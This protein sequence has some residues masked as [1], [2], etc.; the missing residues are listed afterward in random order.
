MADLSTPANITKKTAMRSEI[1]RR[2]IQRQETGVLL[3]LV[4]MCVVIT[5]VAP[6]F[7][8]KQNMY[9]LSRQISLLAIVALGEF[10]TILTGGIDLSVGSIIGFSGVMCGLSLASGLPPGIA[11]ILG[12][13]AGFGAGLLTGWLV[14]YVGLTPF[15]PTLGML[16]MARGVIW[17]ITKGWPVTEIPEAF[18]VLGR[19]EV[20]GIPFPVVI[21][22]VLALVC[23]GVLKYT[24]FG[25]RIFAIGGN[26]E[27]AS[28]SGV[29]V[30]RIKLFI[31]AISSFCASITGIIM[32]ARFNSAQASMGVSWELD[33]IASAVI[34]GA[35]LAGGGGSVIGV[36]IG[37]SII[38]V[39]QNGLVLMKVSSYWQT[40]I[41]GSIIIFAAVVDK[42]KARRGI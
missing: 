9:L 37:A 21:M 3:A 23:H 27:A 20:L 36:L 19:G 5:L 15:I 34:G 41:I 31:Y 38:G 7:A 8:T 22:I 33:A 17:V 42:L 16:S 25:R 1:G 18:L 40:L 6:R 32:V 13:A 14:A 28:L 11:V 2:L 35:S 12:L 29:N 39:I 30:K 10:F 26:E 4:M 24:I